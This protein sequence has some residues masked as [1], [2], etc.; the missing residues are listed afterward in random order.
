MDVP[1][2]YGALH[3]VILA[4]YVIYLSQFS[5]W[6]IVRRNKVNKVLLQ[7]SEIHDR[8]RGTLQHCLLD[9]VK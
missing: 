2:Q 6:L 4:A 5:A 9:V 7:A 8:H 3:W 1:I